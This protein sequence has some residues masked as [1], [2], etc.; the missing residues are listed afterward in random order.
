MSPRPKIVI[1]ASLIILLSSCSCKE[2]YPVAKLN[3][4]ANRVINIYVAC[5]DAPTDP[6]FY[7]IAVDGKVIIEKRMMCSGSYYGDYRFEVITAMNGNLVGVIETSHPENILALHD[8]SANETWPGGR[9]DQTPME[10]YKIGEKLLEQLQKEH[11]E[12]KL[13]I[14]SYRCG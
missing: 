8:F 9:D 10:H 13:N 3:A 14:G 6:I 4:G 12:K 1:L 5:S 7:E 2:A 11:P